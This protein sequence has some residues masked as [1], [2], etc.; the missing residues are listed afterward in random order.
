MAETTATPE[1]APAQTATETQAQEAPKYTDKQLNDLIAKNKGKG[2]EE[3]LKTAGFQTQDEL[4]KALADYKAM[5]DK[6]KT[7]AEKLADENKKTAEKLAE[8]EKKAALADFRA[9]ALAQG[10]SKEASE[11]V[12]KWAQ[13]Y[14]GKTAEEKITA[15][16]KDNPQFAQS[17][18]KL[19]APKISSKTVSQTP[20]AEAALLERIKKQ[21]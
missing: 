19:A 4:T 16:L 15:F 18:A 11:K 2:V 21:M 1:T 5:Q 12:A 17:E 13:D 20:D 8:A 7:D 9:E 6:N 3:L 14:D 10:V